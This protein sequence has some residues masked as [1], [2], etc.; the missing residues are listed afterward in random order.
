MRFDIPE[1]VRAAIAAAVDLT[2]VDVL[3]GSGG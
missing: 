1:T 3:A 2:G